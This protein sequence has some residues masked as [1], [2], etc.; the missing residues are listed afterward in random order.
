MYK[1]NPTRYD[2]MKYNY[3]GNSGLKLS[4]I[5]LGMWQN[6]G[7][8]LPFN[9]VR[10]MVLAA[11][12]AGVTHFDLANNYGRP[13][14]SAES[15]LGRI[16]KE[17]LM[18]YRDEIIISTKAGYGMWEGPYGDGGSRKYLMAS[19]NQSLNRL[20]LDYVDIFYHHRPDYETPLR[21]TMNA[22]ADI[23]KQGKALY[24]G[25]SNYPADRAKEAADILNEYG[26]KLL[27]T[28]PRF[29]MF[30]RWIQT[31]G[32]VEAMVDKGVGI[33][34]Y[35]ILFQGMLTNK[36]IKG[37]PKD[38]RMG[39]KDVVFLQDERITPEYKIAITKL[40]DIADKRNQSIA[41]LAL[42]WTCAQKGIS[43]VLVGI[44]RLSQL[45]SNLEAL[46]NLEFTNEELQEIDDIV[47][48]YP[49]TYR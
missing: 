37:I 4:Q 31:E 15:N 30:E 35:S 3:V 27:I 41:Q 7:E 34:P 20:G 16:L 42:A 11:F 29:N 47:K 26:V 40:K 12:D 13:A 46:I 6:F 32:L 44:S 38:S 5:S 14:G 49:M 10:E 22:L 24:V 21:E 18:M 33:I 2:H 17:D 19:L 43:S 8:E 23:V 1:A 48:T 39:N 28:Q 36:Y 9:Q 45:E 25:L